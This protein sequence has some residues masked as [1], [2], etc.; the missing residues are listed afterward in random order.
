MRHTGTA[1]VGRYAPAD[2]LYLRWAVDWLHDGL[3]RWT[4]P[5]HH[6]AVQLNGI[7]KRHGASEAI[8]FRNYL[9]WLGVTP[10]RFRR[11]ACQQ[12]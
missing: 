12:K 7:R 4:S 5:R 11:S 9:L 2:P 1:I 8:E 6:L 10:S 3:D